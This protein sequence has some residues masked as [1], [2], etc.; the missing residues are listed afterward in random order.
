MA[1]YILTN[2]AV[3]DLSQIWNYTVEVWSESQ[4][5]KYYQLLLHSFQELAKRKIKGKKYT[6]IP[7]DIFGFKAGQ[8]II[9]Y[10]VLEDKTIMIVRILHS[11]MDLRRRI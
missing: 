9:F 10:R 8:H 2:K 4:A 3:E 5:D 11:R 7:N 6:E 1:I